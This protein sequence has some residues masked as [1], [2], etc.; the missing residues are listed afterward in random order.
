MIEVKG[1]WNP[2]KKAASRNHTLILSLN[3]FCNNAARSI[4]NLVSPTVLISHPHGRNE[5]GINK[6]RLW[7]SL[8]GNALNPN[9]FSVLVVGYE[10]KTTGAF[11]EELKRRSR[12]TVESVLVL[13]GGTLNAIREGASKVADLVQE[14]SDYHRESIPISEFTFGLKCGGSDATSGIASNPAL[15]KAVDKIIS[16]NGTV[17]FSETTE[18]IGAEHILAKRGINSDVSKAIMEAAKR[19]EDL[20]IS[21]GVD[22]IGTNPVPDNIKGGISTIEEKSIASIMKSGSSPIKGVLDYATPPADKGLYFMD[23]PS[24]ATEVLTALTAAGSSV[25][26]FTTGSG[27]PVGS[28]IAPVIKITGNPIS[29]LTMKDHI[30]VDVSE[31]I[32]KGK[33]VDFGG[34]IILKALSKVLSGRL[35]KSE[36]LHHD[37]FSPIPVG[38]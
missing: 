23:S 20:A 15:G 11:V 9:V 19:N 14:N 26:L 13:N 3:S 18:I 16:M 33:S 10:E 31:I 6:D 25:I 1:Y 35:T 17:I 8:L 12:K 37:E 29:I 38:L 22:L 27:N 28:P 5:I 4:H 36:I 32:S 21:L 7:K 34:E 30:D 2:D 24:A